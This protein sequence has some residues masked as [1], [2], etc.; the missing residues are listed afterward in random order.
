[1]TAQIENHPEVF[2][3][4][5]QSPLEKGCRTVL[6]PLPHADGMFR[7]SEVMDW[8]DFMAQVYCHN[9]IVCEFFR[10]ELPSMSFQHAKRAEACIREIEEMMPVFTRRHP[11]L[12][13]LQQRCK[14]LC[15]ILCGE[16][17][18]WAGHTACIGTFSKHIAGSADKWPYFSRVL[19]ENN[20]LGQRDWRQASSPANWVKAATNNIAQKEYWVPDYAVDPKGNKEKLSIEAEEVADLPSEA[21]VERRYTQRSLAELEAAVRDDNEVAEYLRSKIRYPDSSRDQIWQQLGWDTARGER[22]DRRYRR[23]RKQLRAI[24]AGMQCRYRSR[25]GLS[26]ASFTSYLEPL[27]DGSHGQENG[28]W[29]HRDP[30]RETE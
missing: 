6:P 16:L 25:Y 21:L 2:V 18:I 23:V 17:M 7:I 19:V 27:W 10:A 29:Q 8:L 1:M 9:S 26:E 5:E 24:G 15:V 20:L 3:S 14:D 4:T 13:P 11:S 30:F 22:V 12:F 28:V